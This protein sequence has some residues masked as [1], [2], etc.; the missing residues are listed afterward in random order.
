MN[1][2]CRL[3][4]E[5]DNRPVFL[6][7]CPIAVGDRDQR[8]ASRPVIVTF[9]VVCRIESCAMAQLVDARPLK[10]AVVEPFPLLT[11]MNPVDR[12]S[13]CRGHGIPS[14]PARAT[15]AAPGGTEAVR[16]GMAGRRHLGAQG[17]TVWDRARHRPS[18]PPRCC[19]KRD[20]RH[21]VEGQRRRL[22]LVER[23]SRACGIVRETTNCWSIRYTGI[24]EPTALSD[25]PLTVRVQIVVLTEI[26]GTLMRKRLLAAGV[27]TSA[28]HGRV[29]LV[30]C[31]SRGRR[32]Y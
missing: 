12:R 29:R 18:R 16:S 8:G 24:S 4:Q 15:A 2:G 11:G 30:R 5:R 14:T 6:R 10:R 3:V 19:R 13:L 28:D 23:V 1:D 26:L 31:C 21:R 17:E 25:S 7:E 27:K 22:V 9:C 20:R 32:E